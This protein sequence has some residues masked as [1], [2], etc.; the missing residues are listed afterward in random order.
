VSMD[1]QIRRLAYALIA[2]FVVLLVQVNYLQ[3]FAADRLAN[4]PRNSRLIILEY[5]VDRGDI[6]ARDAQ[7]RL[8]FSRPSR[9]ALKFLRRY[10]EPELY[11]GIT[12]HYSVVYGRSELEESYN[13]FLAARAEELLPSTLVD[14]LFG[15]RKRGATVI[16]TIDRE[17]QEVASE[18]LAGRPGAVAAIDPRSGQVLALVSNPSYDPNRL[19]SHNTRIVR[20]AWRQLN[21]DPDKP[22]I[23]NA[24]DELHAPGSTFK[25]ITAAAAL[26]NGMTPET[27]FPNP[28]TLDLPQTTV[29]LANAG[30]VHCN[31]GADSITL[32]DA[33][34]ESCNVT[35][36]GIGLRLGAEALREQAQRFG[37]AGT[38][39]FDI[40]FAEGRFPPVEF[41]EDRQPAVAF[42][43][44]GLQDIGTNPL[45]MALVAGAIGNDGVM[46]EPQ[47]VLE[48]R[49]PRGLVIRGFRE[50]EYGRPVSTQTAQAL[51]AMMEAVVS[52][53]TGTAAQIPGFRVAGKTGTALLG[54][55]I[56]PHVWFTAFA[57]VDDPVIAVSAVLLNG[58]GFG[59]EASGG[60]VAAPV[61]RAVLEAALSRTGSG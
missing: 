17:L 39:P 7:T 1:R 20:A 43:A 2:L 26:E 42:S 22:L 24:N 47:L 53:G 58:G 32:F 34:V 49:D 14:L 46:M 8:A 33:F 28:A 38:V 44:I 36:G 27:E 10:P 50:R 52:S 25:M 12:G 37:F 4:H 45:G 30:G 56:P 55:G 60:T 9:G 23:S 15:R 5:R 18:G 57:P 41:F 6:L 3:V 48:V 11:A 31:G 51:Q 54:E 35:F 61:V 13:D 19:S 40:N 29:N 16:S 59:S 21:A